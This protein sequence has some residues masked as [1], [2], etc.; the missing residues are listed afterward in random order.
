MATSRL[1]G[2]LSVLHLLGWI[3]HRTSFISPL[4][5]GG[6]TYLAYRG[7]IEFKRLY[8]GSDR[9]ANPSEAVETIGATLRGGILYRL[10]R[11]KTPEAFALDESFSPC[12]TL[13]LSG[14]ATS[15]EGIEATTEALLVAGCRHFI[16]VGFDAERWEQGLNARS[17]AYEAAS[18]TDLPITVERYEGVTIAD[19]IHLLRVAVSSETCSTTENALIILT[20][21]G[22]GF[23]ERV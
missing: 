22:Q 4:V 17:A 23:T 19:A 11:V 13:I 21:A 8:E 20:N 10:V 6:V 15:T 2:A 12:P 14:G 5:Y 7:F 18:V 9:G 16:C 3:V 1:N